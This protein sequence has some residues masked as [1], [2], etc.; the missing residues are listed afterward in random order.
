MSTHVIWSVNTWR[1]CPSYRK[2][3]H[4]WTVAKLLKTDD[5]MSTHGDSVFQLKKKTWNVDTCDQWVQKNRKC[6]HMFLMMS[7]HGSQ[8]NQ[9]VSTHVIWSVDTWRHCPSYRKCRHMWTIA[10]LLKTDD[11]MLTHGD[12]VFQLKTK[13]LKCRHMFRKCRHMW[14]VSLEK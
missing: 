8:K 1:Q 10:K 6:R 12:S 13:D 4:M 9:K 14:P 5:Q 2:C 3:R 7:T 11:Q